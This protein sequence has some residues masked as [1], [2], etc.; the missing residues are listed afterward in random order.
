MIPVLLATLFMGV[1]TPAESTTAGRETVDSGTV[2][3]SKER[4]QQRL[5]E[6]LEVPASEKQ[7]IRLDLWKYLMI[8]ECG[9]L[10]MFLKVRNNQI[11]L[12]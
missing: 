10:I 11:E 8:S 9:V 12:N 4:V 2:I 6:M 5:R 7:K 1:A 3:A